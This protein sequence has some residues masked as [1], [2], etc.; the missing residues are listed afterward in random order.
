MDTI[1]I[2]LK[3]ADCPTKRQEG[4]TLPARTAATTSQGL[5][6]YVPRQWATV[7]KDKISVS[8]NGNYNAYWH[9]SDFTILQDSFALQGKNI[10]LDTLNALFFLSQ[11]DT[12][13]KKYDWSY[14]SGWERI[15]QEAIKLPVT[16]N[17]SID[18]EFMELFIKELKIQYMNMVS[19]YLQETGLIS[20]KLTNKE[21]YAITVFPNV[22]WKK[23]HLGELF[24]IDKIVGVN[25][26]KLTNGNE[27]D[28]I[29]RTSTNQGILQTTGFIEDV[30]LNDRNTWSLGLLQLDFFYRQKP[31]YAGQYVRRITPKIEIPTTT[32][33]FFTT[34]LN[35]QKDKLSSVLVRDID[36]KFKNIETKLPILDNGDIDFSFIE[37]LSLAI[38]KITIKNVVE[39]I[40]NGC[41][42]S[43]SH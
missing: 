4:Y 32:V 28:Y 23:F 14:K 38:Q 27:F 34:M 3:K 30:V 11:M 9:D 33:C 24:D 40:E 42:K 35:S 16:K 7:L 6:C 17:G 22:Q 5:S 10:E 18:F 20:Y 31:W 25:T 43:A 29:T 2:G 8:A 37:N 41:T 19:N 21:Q 26:D 36:N 15:K 1:K 12:V 13:L 39:F